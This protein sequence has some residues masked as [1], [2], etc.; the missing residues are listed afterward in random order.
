VRL[1][2]TSCANI[3]FGYFTPYAHLAERADLD[4]VLYLGDYLY[5][6]ANGTYGDGRALG[7]V[8]EPDRELLSLAD[9]RARHAQYK[10]DPDL[11]AV[12]RQHPA[13]AVWDDHEIANDAWPGGAQNHDVAREGPYAERRAAAVRAWREWMPVRE[14]AMSADPAAAPPRIWRGFRFGDLA[15]LLMLDTRLEGRVLQ[16]ASATDARTLAD[17]ARSLLGAAQERWLFER[18]SASQREGVAWRVLGQQ[19]L[20][21]QVRTAEG[22]IRNPDAWDGYPAARARVFEH[23]SRAAIRD[24]VVLTGD[25]HS[26][27]ALDLAPDPFD[28]AAYDPA[29]GRGALAVEFVTPAVSSAPP[30]RDPADARAREAEYAA[31]LPHLRWLE[32]WHRGYLLLDLDRTRA[33]AEWWHVDGVEQ[34]G[35]PARFAAGLATRAGASHLEPVAGPSEPPPEAPPLVS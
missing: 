33:Q 8:P 12:H 3:P 5:E 10:A 16:A 25:V 34:R 9:Y 11:Q 15:E 13:I 31:R 1:A 24:V 30:G 21:G 32:F 22:T 26:S 35:L 7:R 17:P 18:L 28:A 14:D 27:W 19:V 23:L 2:A 20:F 4:A 29:S 6:Y